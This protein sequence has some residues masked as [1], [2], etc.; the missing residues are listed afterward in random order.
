MIELSEQEIVAFIGRSLLPIEKASLALR[1]EVANA[2]LDELLG[3]N[4]KSYQDNP[5]VQIR[6][7]LAELFGLMASQSESNIASKSVEGFRID[8]RE[9]SDIKRDFMKR[10]SGV[11]AK[12]GASTVGRAGGIRHGKTIYDDF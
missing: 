9:G 7:M 6:Q 3:G 8:F 1:L 5:P 2:E 10:F 11:I 4:L 12:F